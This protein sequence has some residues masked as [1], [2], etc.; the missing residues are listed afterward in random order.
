MAL[1]TFHLQNN[2]LDT[3]REIPTN[4]PKNL[5]KKIYYLESRKLN[6]D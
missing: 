4:V 1:F 6:P 2:G 3:P 5:T